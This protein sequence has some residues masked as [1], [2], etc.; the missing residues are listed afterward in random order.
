MIK[1]CVVVLALLPGVCFAYPID[2]QKQLDDTDILVTAHDTAPDM[3]AVT[4]QNYGARAV[5]CAL[6]QWPRAGADPA[7]QRRRRGVDR[8]GGQLQ[9]QH[10]QVANRGAMPAE[11]VAT[12]TDAT[13][14][15]AM[16]GQ[17]NSFDESR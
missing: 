16:I 10:S 13:Q 17:D 12:G 3:A 8:R 2:V 5:Q 9:A 11:R 4:L 6:S 14:G 1:C 15:R 7:G